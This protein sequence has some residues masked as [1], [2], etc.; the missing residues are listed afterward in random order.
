MKQS[1]INNYG[2]LLPKLKASRMGKTG[3]EEINGIMVEKK[4][5]VYFE[6]EI[7]TFITRGKKK[8]FQEK[9]RK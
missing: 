1:T 8:N 2:N 7:L 4:T 5:M 6:E 3:V 9:K